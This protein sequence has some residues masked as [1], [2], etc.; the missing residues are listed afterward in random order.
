MMKRVVLGLAALFMVSIPCLGRAANAPAACARPPAGS[1]ASAPAD[2]FSTN[3]VLKLTLNYLTSTDDAG[4]TL[5]CFVTPDGLESPTLHVYPGDTLKIA[6]TN[7]QTI[8]QQIAA[9]DM[10]SP[11]EAGMNMAPQPGACTGGEMSGYSVNLHFHGINASPKCKSDETIRTIVNPGETFNYKVTIPTDEPPGLYWYHPHVHGISAGALLGGASGAIVVEGIEN[12][13]PK[14]AKLPERVVVIRDQQVAGNPN[15]G[16][17]VP[18]YD[19]SVDYT[20]IAYPANKPAIMEI[21][22]GRREFWRVL[23]ASADQISD[24]Q[25]TYDG[26]AQTIELI[27]LDGVPLG[28]QDGTRTGKIQ[29]VTHILLPPAGRA[30]FIMTSPSSDVQNARFETLKIHGGPQQDNNIHR[31]LALLQAG[32]GPGISQRLMPAPSAPPGP[33]RFEGLDTAQVTAHR[34]LYFYEIGSDQPHPGGIKQKDTGVFYIVVDGQTPEP[35]DPSAKPA[36]TTTQGAVEDWRIENRT[37]EVHE[38]HIHQIHFQVRDISGVPVPPNERQFRDTFQVP[39]WSGHGPYPSVTVRMD[40]RGDIAGDFVYHCHILDH[41]DLGMMA[42]IRVLPSQS[43][44][45]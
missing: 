27:G 2:I 25:L 15:P 20:P 10:V 33:Q 22:P 12:L 28:S 31:T 26:V 18:S 3:G 44:T 39:F 14:V 19:V 43:K 35:F 32:D 7:Q 45:P 17:R 40:F 9:A 1:V 37:Q 24:L 11:A 29:K 4:R 8:P 42:K 16:G 21:I 6:L 23:N 30:E 38:F 36:I 41:E 13:Q 5:Y 34:R